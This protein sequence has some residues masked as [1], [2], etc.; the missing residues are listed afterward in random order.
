MEADCRLS[1]AEDSRGHH[2][3]RVDTL[4]SEDS[5]KETESG[6]RRVNAAVCLAAPQERMLHQLQLRPEGLMDKATQQGSRVR[7]PLC[8]RANWSLRP[9]FTP[10]F[11]RRN[12]YTCM[13]LLWQESS[14]KSCDQEGLCCAAA[15]SWRSAS[16]NRQPSPYIDTSTTYGDS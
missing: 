11:L 7:R 14:I 8:T 9:E 10:T 15:Q 3:K 2:K 16:N 4:G 1:V 5:H 12:T 6:S 13:E